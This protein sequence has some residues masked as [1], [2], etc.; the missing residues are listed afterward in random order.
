M[1]QSDRLALYMQTLREFPMVLDTVQ[2]LDG[3][4]AGAGG[5]LYVAVSI[6]PGWVQAL[7]VPM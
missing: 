6:N 4:K 5:F 2:S 3:R 7:P 1:G